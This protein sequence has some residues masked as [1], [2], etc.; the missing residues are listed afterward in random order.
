V[1]L[2]A[3][4]FF[5]SVPVA[6]ESTSSC[7]ISTLRDT[8]ITVRTGNALRLQLSLRASETGRPELTIPAGG[9]SQQVYFHGLSRTGS[10]RVTFSANG[11]RDYV[12]EIPHLDSGF[13][14]AN[15]QPYSVAVNGVAQAT[16]EFYTVSAD[17]QRGRPVPE[18]IR[19]GAVPASVPV[20]VSDPRLISVTPSSL[21]FQPGE[22]SK[23]VQI[24]G[25]NPG[26]ATVELGSS[27]GFAPPTPAAILVRVN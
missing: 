12:A 16:V 4:N 3:L 18:G 13:F 25:L 15:T 1:Q 23:S 9:S 2:P 22:F 24:R 7:T 8:P 27:A 20:R 14:F 5:C 19:P 11:Y 6:N 10:T 26:S 21:V 17:G